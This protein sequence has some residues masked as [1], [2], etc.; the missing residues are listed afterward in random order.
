[1][2]NLP[3]PDEAARGTLY[4]QIVEERAT[5]IRRL[6]HMLENVSFVRKS[7]TA[8]WTERDFLNAPELF[9]RSGHIRRLMI[10]F[11]EKLLNDV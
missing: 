5:A 2:M 6:V 7:L 9:L 4:L 3:G 8:I 1:M 11:G 10:G